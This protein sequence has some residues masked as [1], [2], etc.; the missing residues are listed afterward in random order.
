[1]SVSSPFVGGLVGGKPSAARRAAELVVDALS[2]FLAVDDLL[3]AAEAGP[4]QRR[5]AVGFS[6]EVK[7][8]RYS[9]ADLRWT[10]L[11]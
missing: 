1:V 7:S 11:P 3:S 6:A 8:Y 4:G 10:G 9:F 5:V 2:G